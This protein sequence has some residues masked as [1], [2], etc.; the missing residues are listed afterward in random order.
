MGLAAGS[1]RESRRSGLSLLVPARFLTVYVNNSGDRG[2]I[3]GCNE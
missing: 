3:V 1:Q 2:V